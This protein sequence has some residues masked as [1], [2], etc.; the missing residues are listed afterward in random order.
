MCN[1]RQVIVLLKQISW[2]TQ[3]G[4]TAQS[5][6]I[7]SLKLCPKD[8]VNAK[9]LGHLSLEAR[10]GK[11]TLPVYLMIFHLGEVCLQ[12]DHLICWSRYLV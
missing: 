5:D 7:L 8:F 9:E 3:L 12:L 6:W 1:L 2:T 10:I 4:L 11:A